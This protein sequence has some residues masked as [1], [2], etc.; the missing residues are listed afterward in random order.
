MPSWSQILVDVAYDSNGAVF[1]L[2]YKG[3]EYAQWILT[4]GC[5]TGLQNA[6]QPEIPGLL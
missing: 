1:V 5:T 2:V 3:I 6:N 4:G